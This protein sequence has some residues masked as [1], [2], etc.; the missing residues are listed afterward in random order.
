MIAWGKIFITG[1]MAVED[2]PDSGLKKCERTGQ[3]P[4]QLLKSED[5][6]ITE[7]EG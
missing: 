1:F 7:R 6:G 3:K 5:R 2:I 4:W